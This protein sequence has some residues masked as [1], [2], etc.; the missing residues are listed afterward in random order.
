M[1]TGLIVSMLS[2]FLA[3][4]GGGSSSGVSSTPVE[5]LTLVGTVATGTAVSGATVSAK[6]RSG[7][8]N[9]T[10]VN[11]GTYAM[12]INAASLPCVL[13]ATI[14]GRSDTLHSVAV[15]NGSVT[16]ARSNLTPLT[17]LLTARLS[18]SDPNTFF[19]GFDANASALI[20][21]TTA[22]GAQVDVATVLASL[23][24][25]SNV[26]N[27][28]GAPLKAALP[29]A[30][31]GGD[32]QDDFL[33]IVK[34]R[35]SPAQF[36]QIRTALAGSSSTVDVAQLLAGLTGTIV[37][38][39]PIDFTEIQ[40]DELDFTE[41]DAAKIIVITD[42]LAWADV[43]GRH[44]ERLRPPLPAVDFTKSMVLGTAER[45][46]FGGTRLRVK[47]IYRIGQKV[48]FEYGPVGL[49]GQGITSYRGLYAVIDRTGYPI[50]FIDL[51]LTG[52]PSPRPDC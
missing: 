41:A 19:A 31:T 5:T 6:C 34:A 30:G 24:D 18:R 12:T 1:R 44:A 11:D 15:E 36:G 38:A 4:C 49:F 9:A 47:R 16:T 43:W 32:A 33:E 40:P 14:P 20:T 29:G 7:A 27:F 46:L 52:C 21:S 48:F 45:V 42:A 3:G 39:V 28:V 25:A 23:G 13:Q 35:L 26:G 51:P 37:T 2:V 17:E 50:E 10:T 8:G 22:A